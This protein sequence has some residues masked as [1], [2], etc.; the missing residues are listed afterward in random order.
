MIEALMEPGAHP[1]GATVVGNLRRDLT[2]R[3]RLRIMLLW[4]VVLAFA[5]WWITSHGY[6]DS[7]ALS[8]Y[9][10]V[11]AVTTGRPMRLENFGLL[12]PH[13]PLFLIVPFCMI[14]ELRTAWSPYL[15]SVLAGAS[16]L[17]IFYARL[18]RAGYP[19]N[20]AIGLG[21]LVATHPFFLWA[22]ST[23]TNRSLGLLAMYLIA[24]GLMRLTYVSDARAHMLAALALALFFFV[25]ESAL[26]LAAAL[27]L[28]LPFFS[29]DDILRKS[30]IGLYTVIYTPFVFAVLAWMYLNWLFMGDSLAFM[31]DHHSSFLGA[32]AYSKYVPYLAREGGRFLEPLAL[33]GA[34]TLLAYPVVVVSAARA[35]RRIS[36]RIR[37]VCLITVPVVAGALATST[38]YLDHPVTVLVLGVTGLLIAI[39]EVPRRERFSSLFLLSLFAG[40]FGAWA[41]MSVLPTTALDQWRD[42]VSGNV[43]PDRYA[44]ERELGRSTRSLNDLMLDDGAGFPAIA[45]RKTGFGLILPFDPQFKLSM[46]TGVLL[47]HYVAVSDPATNGGK[48]AIAARFP[49][50]YANGDPRYRLYNAVP[51]WRVY[52]RLAP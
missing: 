32:L 5:T 1:I 25:D 15:I 11:L 47:A 14:A 34:L 16:V 52:E 9:A 26:Y 42:A 38:R 17:T 23:G 36:L 10:K 43:V 39:S 51:G 20:A 13:V 27:V 44:A 22:V 46:I 30:P 31:R 37:V 8:N 4:T 49:T 6:T 3:F 28:A 29:D 2:P 19:P 21:L 24:L 40:H 35:I 7:G 50:L 33:L 18:R 12:Y 45:E 41:A 48:D